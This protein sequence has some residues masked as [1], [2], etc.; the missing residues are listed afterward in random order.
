M[1][2][3]KVFIGNGN[4]QEG[5]QDRDPPSVA[6]DSGGILAGIGTCRTGWKNRSGI[7]GYHLS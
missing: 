3:V 1:S 7:C 6:A 2:I 5:H 4:G